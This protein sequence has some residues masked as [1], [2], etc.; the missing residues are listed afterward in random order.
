MKLEKHEDIDEK[1]IH[2]VTERYIFHLKE[3]N[4]V[5]RADQIMSS[6]RTDIKRPFMVVAS[7]VELKRNM[8]ELA[9]DYPS[10]SCSQMDIDNG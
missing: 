9:F 7:N 1:A 2:A 5:S 8:V 6:H 4:F 3:D 10:L